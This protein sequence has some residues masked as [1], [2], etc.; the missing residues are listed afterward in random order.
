VLRHLAVS[1]VLAG[2]VLFVANGALS[3]RANAQSCTY[4]GVTILDG[5]VT[6]ACP[7]LQQNERG[8]RYTVTSQ[9]LRCERGDLR[10]QQGGI[11]YGREGLRRG[12]ALREMARLRYSLPGCR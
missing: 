5:A 2:F 3:D 6:C 7:V 10:L 11:C 8:N 12:R 4:G 1:A 9:T